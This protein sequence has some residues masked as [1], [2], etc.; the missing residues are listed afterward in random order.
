MIILNGTTGTNTPP[1]SIQGSTSGTITLAAPAVAGSN[2]QTLVAVTGTLAPIVSGTTVTASGTSVDFTGIPAYAQRV[3]VSFAGLST[4]G[5][6]SY[7]VQIGP[8]TVPE[9]T[10]YASSSSQITATPS[11][12]GSTAGFIINTGNASTVLSGTMVLSLLNSA[13][14]LWAASSV[15]A[16]TDNNAMY[17]SAGSKAIA[18]VLGVV[19][20]T[21][22][23]GT[24]TFDAGSI[25]IMWE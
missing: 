9:T 1:V 25:N 24:D 15:A 23:N 16:R 22:V 17:V 4:S 2:T 20:I 19:R 13:T 7:L 10:V 5:S 14:N 12:A 11:Q 3:T 21:T 6:S 18:A 8:T